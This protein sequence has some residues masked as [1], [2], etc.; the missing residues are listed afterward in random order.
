[1]E[2]R[3]LCYIDFETYYSTK[4][5]YSLKCMSMFE[6]I[7]DPRFK[8]FGAGISM[9]GKNPIWVPAHKLRTVFSYT[10]W[11]QMTVVAHNVK[12][13][14]AILRW[15]Y[16]INPKQYVDTLSMSRAVLGCQLP[17]H[18]LATVARHFGLEPKGTLR[19]D[20]LSELTPEQEAELARYCIHDTDLCITLA[21]L[22]AHGFPESQYEHMDWTIRCFIDPKLKLDEKKLA[23]THA[24]EAARRS[25]IF[26]EIGIDKSVFSSNPKFAALLAD[27]GYDVPTKK[28]KNS[29]E[30]P[31][32]AV[33]DG[34]FIELQQL[35]ATENDTLLENLCEARIAAKSTLLETR[36]AKLLAVSKLGTFPF[37]LNFSGAVN[38]HRYSGASGAG[39]NPQNLQKCQDPKEHL[40]HA[41]R[42]ALRAAVTVPEKHVLVLADFSAVE[43]RI[44]S[45]LAREGKLIEILTD[46]NGDPY[47]VFA[48]K[49]Y[50]RVITK[51]DKAERQYGKC[52]VLGLG[53][54]MGPKK[55]IFQA[56]SQAKMIIDQEEA[57]RVV[58]LYRDEYPRIPAL[59][60]TLDHYIPYIAE[61][62]NVKLPG[63]S[64]LE[65]KDGCVILPSG[66]RLQYPN[67]RKE[68]VGKH[69]EWIFDSKGTISKLYGGKL[70]ENISQALGQELCKEAI[71]RARAAG[72]DCVGQCHDEILAVAPEERG[73]EVK[74]ILID[75]MER[76]I[77]WWPTIKLYAEGGYGANW[78]EAKK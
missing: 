65:I 8:A 75:S 23:E 43:L 29:E 36:S 62:A 35:A 54:N 16:G 15:I 74:A 59:W 24:A 22:L 25:N 14:G 41:C 6:Y 58:Y 51:A 21:E 55:F 31:A 33:T 64:F 38:T 37:D 7:R 45:W 34:G 47:V 70:L 46:R 67:L 69:D 4:D 50:H 39:G 73:P 1:M 28:N 77:P 57:E 78:L 30:I 17:N 60:E 18:S 11:S 66:L 42:G 13:D 63:M 3:N 26:T 27:N 71:K 56:R 32:L 40:T 9:N 48:S 76:T 53:Y 10:D 49:I 68:R 12:F 61:K 52:A 72:V 5:K 2:V 20:G 44:V 19:T